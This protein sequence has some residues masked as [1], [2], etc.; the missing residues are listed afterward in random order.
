[1][2]QTVFCM[3]FKAS[4]SSWEEEDGVCFLLSVVSFRHQ[5]V[6]PRRLKRSSSC[7][8]GSSF[9]PRPSPKKSVGGG[10]PAVRSGQSCS[11]LSWCR[12]EKLGANAA[13]QRSD[14]KM[15]K[16]RPNLTLSELTSPTETVHLLANVFSLHIGPNLDQK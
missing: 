14:G 10:N 15:A 9:P 13:G 8:R 5:R 12:R 16:K 6:F 7:H 2:H 3:I 1:M 11:R 4:A